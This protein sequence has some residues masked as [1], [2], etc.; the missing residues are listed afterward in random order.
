MA[1]ASERS[2]ARGTRYAGIY[3]DPDGHKRSIVRRRRSPITCTVRPA[4]EQRSR[5]RDDHAGKLVH[6]ADTNVGVLSAY[7]GTE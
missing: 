4:P 1:W 6:G 3:R 7:V 5:M 2:G